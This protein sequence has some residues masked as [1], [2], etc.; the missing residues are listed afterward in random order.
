[1][2]PDSPKKREGPTE[3]FLYIV[4]G[5][6]STLVRVPLGVKLPFHDLMTPPEPIRIGAPEIPIDRT[7]PTWRVKLDEAL[8]TFG[9]DVKAD[10]R[11]VRVLY[12]KGQAVP[13]KEWVGRAVDN[14]INTLH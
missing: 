1:M 10:R 3:L 12:P 8:W 5:N 13:S 11:R 4:P 14:L 9:E 7:A 6:I 2:N